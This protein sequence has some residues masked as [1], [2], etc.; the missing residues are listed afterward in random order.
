[1][2]DGRRP[3]GNS[4]RRR[5]PATT[6][7]RVDFRANGDDRRLPRRQHEPRLKGHLRRGWRT[8]R[9]A[10]QRHDPRMTHA[11]AVHSPAPF[12]SHSIHSLSP[13]VVSAPTVLVFPPLSL[14]HPACQSGSCWC[15]PTVC[16]RLVVRVRAC[17]CAWN[18]SRPFVVGDSVALFHITVP[19]LLGFVGAGSHSQLA[20]LP[21]SSYLEF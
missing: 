9:R 5:R 13:P 14:P 20:T 8:K 10:A 16:I 4:R 17:V 11:P 6:R 1:M 21:N 7:G 19:R 18:V 2:R 3:C 15:N 12:T